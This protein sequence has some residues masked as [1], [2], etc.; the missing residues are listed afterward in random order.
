MS[1]PPALALTNASVGE[2]LLTYVCPTPFQINFSWTPA[3][4]AVFYSLQLVGP[5]DPTINGAVS[6][7]Y[8]RQFGTI[9]VAKGTI[10]SASV[11][12]SQAAAASPSFQQW[13]MMVG[14]PNGY[15]GLMPRMQVALVPVP[16]TQTTPQPSPY[17]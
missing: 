1:A 11:S 16:C 17:S 14:G 13:Q 3:T 12:L 10:N 9:E 15:L 7:S 8:I 4:N 6:G 2:S 5:L